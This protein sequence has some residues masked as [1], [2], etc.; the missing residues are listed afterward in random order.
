M[1]QAV[2][3]SESVSESQSP[4]DNLHYRGTPSFHYYYSCTQA[5]L[6]PYPLGEF[7]VVIQQPLP[8]KSHLQIETPLTTTVSEKQR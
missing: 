8:Q 1:T 6:P 3:S 7:Q 5:S 4:M 2:E